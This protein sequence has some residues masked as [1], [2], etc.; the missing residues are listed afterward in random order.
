MNGDI[1]GTS[2][3][4]STGDTLDSAGDT[5]SVSGSGSMGLSCSGSGSGSGLLKYSMDENP[6][7]WC[8]LHRSGSR[9]FPNGR[10]LGWYFGGEG[11]HGFM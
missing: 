8:W 9:A 2:G 6:Q 10:L 11:G 7:Q 1:I 5:M 3:L 4:D